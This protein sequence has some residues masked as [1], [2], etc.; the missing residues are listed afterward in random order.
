MWLPSLLLS[1]ALSLKP[2]AGRRPATH[3]NPAPRRRSFVP[4]LEA[5]EAR[6]VPI[7][8]AFTAG[9]LIQVSQDPDPLAGCDDGYR[10]D[11]NMNFSDEFETR[12]AVDPSNPQHLVATWVGHDLQ[13]NFVG[14]SF[15]GGDTWR[16][17]ALPGSTP[18]TGGPFTSA[19]DRELGWKPV[20][21]VCW[22]AKA[23][24]GAPGA[25]VFSSTLTL[26][27]A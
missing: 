9:P 7:T 13:S 11:G 21:K 18:C 14:V 1:L 22:A 20:A 6:T 8:L 16:E 25:V 2:R 17:T 24:V 3:R 10:P 4:R 26:L 23:S 27:L 19:V 12:V 15:D 5:L